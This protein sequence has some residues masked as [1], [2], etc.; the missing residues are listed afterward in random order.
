[1]PVLLEP[2]LDLLAPAFDTAEPTMIDATLG[3]GGHTEG[4][5]RRFEGLTIIGID[6]DP[7]ALKLA[8]RRLAPFGDRFVPFLGTY[9]QIPDAARGIRVDGVL[10]DLGVSSMQLDL[11]ERGF[12]YSSDAPLD[13]RMNPEE[14]VS[15]AELINTAD[16]KELVR[17][18]RQG[19]D[20]K[21]APQ[22]ARLIVTRRSEKPFETTS[23]LVEVVK[24]AIPAPARR[25]GGNP[26]KRTFQ[27]IRVAVNDELVILK[28][29][30][31]RA[32]ETLRVGGRIVI[33]S[34]QSLEDRIVKATFAEG[35]KTQGS[36]IPAGVPVD[37]TRAEQGKRLELL[38]HG[39]R[40]ATEQE[41]QENPRA[42]SV[43]LRA[44]ELIAPWSEQ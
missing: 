3:L 8:S 28:R 29:A 42:A 25:K 13:M 31:P 12:S 5:L 14:G 1:M 22:I 24:D 15:A 16:E 7:R 17:I 9:D 30:L 43:R 38:T 26:A 39:A 20:E 23:E 37:A 6:R 4:A 36:Q 11:N 34:Y 32:L 35:T 44:A 2:C 19:S 18:L 10:M 27:A 40:K 33:E 21:F 41:I